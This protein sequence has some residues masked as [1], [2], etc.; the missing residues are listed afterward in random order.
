MRFAVIA[1]VTTLAAPAA[2][3]QETPSVKEDFKD[4]GR[5][6][7]HGVKHGYDKT[8]DATVHGVGKA[9]DKTGEGLNKAGDAVERA[10]EKV[11]E[12]VE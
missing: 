3:A 5:A 11:E 1:L 2:F 6:V 12:K 4:A 9:L 7:E 8:K 10:G